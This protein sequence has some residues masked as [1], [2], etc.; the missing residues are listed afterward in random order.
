MIMA[1]VTIRFARN[2]DGWRKGDETTVSVAGCR[3]DD[4]T[5]VREDRCDD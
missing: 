5:R 3:Q 4:H 2:V 1:E